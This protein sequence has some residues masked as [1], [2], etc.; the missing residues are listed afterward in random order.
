MKIG[1]FMHNYLPRIG[2][3]QICAH[4]LAD[5][6]LQLGH[7]IIVYANPTMV[8]ECQAKNWTFSYE[9][10][11][12]KPPFRVIG[13]YQWLRTLGA[14]QAIV[15][16][17]KKDRLDVVQMV[18]AWPWLP[19]V[20]ELRA[21]TGVPVVIRCAG[22]DIQVDTSVGY[23][24]RREENIDGLLKRGF[25]AINQGIAI[26][27]TVT[28]E[29]ERAGL[30]IQKISEIPPGVDIGAFDNVTVS[31]SEVRKRWGLPTDKKLIISVGRNHPKK[32]FLDLVNALPFL[33]QHNDDFAVVV[34]GRETDQLRPQAEE[35]DVADA[36]YT[37]NE[38]AGQSAEISTFPSVGLIELYKASD[39]FVLPSYIETY[40]NVALEA[41]AAHIPAIV[42][43]APG[44]ID[45]VIHEKDGLIIPVSSPNS[46]AKAIHR[47]ES[48]PDLKEKII[49]QGREKAQAQDWSNISQKYLDVY[50]K[51]RQ[52]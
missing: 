10:K 6:L 41:M 3:A 31:K 14:A 25:E 46:I 33:N 34:V 9:L 16:Q 30:D 51:V 39:Y 37:I 7:E 13:K 29:Y 43:D 4:C 20:R 49:S 24:I 35:K 21:L 50:H 12:I 22:D 19:V 17:V 44:C 27:Q 36:F 28:R 52:T 15:R 48:T 32:G 26:S 1:I 38:I 18:V 45:T 42:T 47:L 11:A 8:A 40:A 5:G 23:G 2:G